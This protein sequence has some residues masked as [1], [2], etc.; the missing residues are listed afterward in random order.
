M[1]RGWDYVPGDHWSTCD[2]CSKK[3][4]ASETRTRWD[5]YQVCKDDFE[6][7]QPQDFVRAKQDK[8]SVP[9]VRPIP[10][11][12]FT[13]VTYVDTGNTTIPPGNNNGNL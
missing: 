11:L 6:N 1:S 9:I 5:G 2:V 10:T 12:V 8:I 13:D 4:K 7:R 3:V